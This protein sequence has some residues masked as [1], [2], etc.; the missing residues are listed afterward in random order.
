METGTLAA[1]THQNIQNPSKRYEEH[2]SPSLAPDPHVGSVW[3]STRTGPK[4][5]QQLLQPPE[6][7][8]SLHLGMS[9][10]PRGD[11]ANISCLFSVSCQSWNF[12]ENKNP[13]LQRSAEATCLA[14]PHHNNPD[15][16]LIGVRGFEEGKCFI[17]NK[18]SELKHQ[19]QGQICP[20]PKLLPA[21]SRPQ[22]C[23]CPLWQSRVA[24]LAAADGAV[25]SKFC[26]IYMLL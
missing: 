24:P 15:Q 1:W 7:T 17:G 25:E 13:S 8:G 12:L 10:G 23:P 5:C 6:R 14:C 4:P 18:S 22:P 21:P 20:N 2:P 26:S 19:P 16:A 3:E 9:Q 11:A